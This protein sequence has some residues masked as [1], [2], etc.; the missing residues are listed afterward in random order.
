MEKA[1]RLQGPSFERFTALNWRKMTLFKI[2]MHFQWTHQE[3]MA[4]EH[5]YVANGDGAS[6]AAAAT[7]DQTRLRIT[8]SSSAHAPSAPF[9]VYSQ[10]GE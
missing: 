9:T 1:A 10:S 8:K 4:F 7:G 5:I 6:A 2:T 3:F